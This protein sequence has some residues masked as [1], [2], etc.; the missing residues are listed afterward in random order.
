MYLGPHGYLRI[1]S[2]VFCDPCLDPKCG[3]RHLLSQSVS[4][5]EKPQQEN[6]RNW[7]Q[8]KWHQTKAIN[9]TESTAP[10]IQ[11]NVHH[12]HSVC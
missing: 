2:S 1:H 5:C 9:K 8:K 3:D 11:N 12:I 10:S 6:G 4:I 7:K